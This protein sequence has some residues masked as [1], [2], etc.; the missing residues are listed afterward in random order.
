MKKYTNTCPCCNNLESILKYV[1]T[2]KLTTEDR[3]KIE[4]IDILLKCTGLKNREKEIKTEELPWQ[5]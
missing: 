2:L 4:M 3:F 1:Q 5:P